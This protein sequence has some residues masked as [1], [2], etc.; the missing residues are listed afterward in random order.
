MK[1]NYT[2]FPLAEIYFNAMLNRGHTEGSADY[3][4]RQ[5]KKVERFMADNGLETYTEQTGSSFLSW[6]IKT[7]NPSREF[8]D[9]V[10]VVVQRLN[11]MA[12]GE[13]IS[14]TK[15]R[16]EAV[17]LPECI[18]NGIESYC[19]FQAGH[20]GLK[21]S[22]LKYHIHTLERFFQ[23]SGVM[24]FSGITLPLIEKGFRQSTHKRA[25]R[26]VIRKFT[27][28]LYQKG[29]IQTDL[30]GRIAQVLPSVP[31]SRPLPSVYSDT[32]I[33]LL[34]DAVDRGTMKGCRDFAILT[35]AARLG[36][37]AS[38]ICGMTL[39]EVDFRHDEIRIVQKKTS[40]P[41]KLPLLPE[42]RDA[43]SDY[44][45]RRCCTDPEDVIFR[46]CQ[47]PHKGLTHTGLWCIMRKYLKASG[48]EPGGRRRG[49]HA[50]RS[51]LASSMV[52]RDVPY[53]AVQKVLGHESPQ[54]AKSYIRI[55]LAGLRKFTIPVPEASGNFA[56]CLEGGGGR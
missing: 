29:Y 5:V 54:A 32:E 17:L 33:A 2:G 38:D 39:G 8:Q 43:L 20:C 21:D 16:K 1:P 24:D 23:E 19:Q 25:Y 53:Y 35:L 18:R 49:P 6:W 14:F 41:L 51:S 4:A 36:L 47:A 46:R 22:T 34:L 31:N 45:D 9:R 11:Q 42:A 52:G 55:D 40:V 37:R 50:L 7:Q 15:P 56:G 13:E 12:A 3:Y 44:I 27:L 26:T 30:S 48:V 10:S 28:F